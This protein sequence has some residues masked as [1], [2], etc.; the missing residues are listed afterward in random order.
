ML[1]PEV[2][3]A[4]LRRLEARCSHPFCSSCPFGTLLTDTCRFSLTWDIW[5]VPFHPTLHVVFKTKCSRQCVPSKGLLAVHLCS[6]HQAIPALS[7]WKHCAL[8]WRVLRAQPSSTVC[9]ICPALRGETGAGR[10][11]FTPKRC[12]SV[13]CRAWL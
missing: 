11:W 9:G 10:S 6:P 13:L 12:S 5:Q 3:T 8:A 1:Q 4:D 7:L 2:I